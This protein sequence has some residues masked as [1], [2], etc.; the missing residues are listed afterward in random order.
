MTEINKKLDLAAIPPTNNDGDPYILP[1]D[2]YKEGYQAYNISNWFKGRVGDNGT[3]FAIRWYSHGRLLN[4]QGMRPFIEGQVGDY[5]IDDSD[6]DN[7]RIDMAEDASNIHI[8]GDVDDTQAGGVAIYRLINQAFP[9][10]G[11]FYGKIGFMG[12]Q[13]DGTL[14]NTGVD[15]VFKVLAGHMNMLGAR[16]F[17]VSELEKA[18][19]DLKEEI[20]QYDQQYKDQTQQQADQFKQDTEKALADLNTKIAN[21][22]KRAE[23]TLGDTQASIDNNL[24]ALKRLSASVGALQAQ[25]DADDLETNTDHKADIAAVKDEIGFRFSQIKHPVQAFD[26]LAQ[27]QAKFPAGADG[28]MLAVDTGHI[29]IYQWDSNQWKDCGVYQSQ[30]LSQAD[31]DGINNALKSTG[32]V[33]DPSKAPYN[34]LDTLPANTILTYSDVKNVKNLPEILQHDTN[35]QGITVTTYNYRS[36]NTVGGAVQVLHTNDNDRFWRVKWGGDDSQY[37]AWNNPLFSD[38]DVI[39]ADSLKPPF[40]N[41]DNLPDNTLTIYSEGLGQ[42]NN[43]P[44]SIDCGAILTFN[45]RQDKYGKFQLLYLEDKTYFRMWWGS[46]LAPHQWQLLTSYI[47]QPILFTE[48]DGSDIPE[49]YQDLNTV[50]LNQVITYSEKIDKIKNY[51]KGLGTGTV[52]TYG[53]GRDGHKTGSIQ[54]VVDSNDNLAYRICWFADDYFTPWKSE[55][56]QNPIMF[57]NTDDIP[58]QYQDLNTLPINQI[59]TYADATKIDKIK[60]YPKGLGTGTVITYGTGRDGH[61]TGSIQIVVDSNDNL[62]YRICWFA[63]D[64]FTPWKIKISYQPKPSLALFRSIGI[65]GDSYASGELAFDGYVDHYN[66]S[67]GQILGRKVG[68]KVINF[69]RGGQTTRGWLSDTE[70]GL[71]LLNK[72]DAQDLYIV[73]LGINDYQKLGES[74]LGTDADIDSGAD[75]YYGNYGKIIKAIQTKAPM[76]KIVIATLSQTDATAVKY[77]S[78]IQNIAKHFNLPC[79]TLTDDPFFTSDFY[80]NHMHGGHPTGPVYAEMANAYERLISQAMVDHLDYF[81]SYEKDLATDNAEDLSRI[82]STEK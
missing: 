56:W 13:D 14:V 73:A 7:I 77:N 5:T 2:I 29:Y 61:K 53:T 25:L 45:L 22:I 10:S 64:Y 59:V 63:D 18:W 50:P 52:I 75:T 30:G 11:I 39:H 57:T 79:V 58:K 81:E 34:D 46:P 24:A 54:I 36:G 43:V 72:A 1:L 31:Q 4:I 80:L 19:L 44:D 69:S 35:L 6:P 23:D 3:P 62:A 15:I 60:N 51:P 49:E 42:V 76:A 26:S 48:T 32:T 33:T 40:D 27:I 28:D 55:F 20:R 8:V 9:K 38:F 66:M 12:T 17:Y 82:A 47:K 21:E 41:C 74:Y 78:A 37:G 65:I 67:W 70:R 16:Q 71:G 68:I